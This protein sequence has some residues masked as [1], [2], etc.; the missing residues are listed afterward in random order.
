MSDSEFQ[1]LETPLRTD[2]P[3]L[4]TTSPVAVFYKQK[5]DGQVLYTAARNGKLTSF[6]AAD[7]S[8]PHRHH[9]FEIMMVQSGIVV[10]DAGGRP[11]VYQAGEGCLMNRQLIHQE[12]LRDG[13]RVV[14]IDLDPDFLITLLAEETAESTGGIFQFL[15]NNLNDRKNWQRSYL[16]YVPVIPVENRPVQIVLDALQQECSTRKIGAPY[17]QAGLTLRLLA[18]LQNPNAFTLHRV[19]LDATKEEHLANM[20]QR[21]IESHYGIITREEIAEALHYNAEYLNRL[22]K[23]RHGVTL[24]AYAKSVRLQKAKQLLV[25]TNFSITEVSE[26]LGFSSGEYFY[27]YFKNASGISPQQYRQLNKRSDT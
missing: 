12:H 24:L 3:I 15:L 1:Q 5:T 9:F 17:F 11:I 13:S 21:L 4:T 2:T 22:F 23:Q 27:R 10:N 18:L 26:K 8:R 14:F 25:I 7:Y 6:T 16:D 20:V 19:D